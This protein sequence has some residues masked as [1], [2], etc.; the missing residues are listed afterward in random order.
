MNNHFSKFIVKII[1]CGSILI[2][3]AG[4]ILYR[5]FLVEEVESKNPSAKLSAAQ[6]NVQNEMK[7][8]KKNEDVQQYLIIPVSSDLEEADILVTNQYMSKT[9]K[10][11]IPGMNAD[12]FKA[13]P[14]RGQNTLLKNVYYEETKKGIDLYLVLDQICEEK[15]YFND[16]CICM[17]FIPVTELYENIVVLDPGHGGKDHG[18]VAYGV[19]E[20]EITMRVVRKVTQ[21]L[22]AE[23]V[24][25]LNTRSTD[26]FVSYE[27]RIQA[28][29]EIQADLYLA[30]HT[31][32]DG[33]T[34]ITN[35]IH[36]YYADSPAKD[37]LTSQ[38]FA[39]LLQNQMVMQTKAFDKGTDKLNAKTE[40]LNEL[41]MPAVMIETGYITNKQEALRLTSD[42]YLNELVQG[43]YDAVLQSYDAMGKDIRRGKK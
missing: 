8:T 29:N 43:V 6:S 42:Y 15:H 33:N 34:R 1:L 18:S 21:M 38:K 3:T 28:A 12:Y 23:D 35:G 2:F 10:L 16:S 31:N 14:V 24:W 9:I 27:N 13:T 5:E 37:G 11:S 4:F 22:Q 39:T 17:E 32:A 20:K 40:A 30:F 36:T 7:E 25:V 26:E 19:V 41:K